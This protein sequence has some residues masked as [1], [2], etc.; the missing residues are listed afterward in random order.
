MKLSLI[1][2]DVAL[3]VEAEQAG[4]DRIMIDL[5]RDGKAERQAGRGLFLSSH[6]IESVAPVKVALVK[7]P[8][9]VRINPLGESSRS[10]IDALVDGGADF[11]MLP[12]FSG[13]AEARVFLG[14]VRRRARVILLVETRSAASQLRALVGEPGVDEVHIGLNDLS[15]S[16]GQDNLFEPIC[17]GI[18]DEMAAVLRAAGMPFG[19]G[20]IG[21]LSRQELPVHPERML[22]EQVRL[23]ASRGWL[24]RTFRGE[25]EQSRARG[26]LAAE[27]LA[28]REAVRKWQA[29]SPGALL[30]NRAAL[31]REAA[32]FVA[33]T[34]PRALRQERPC[35]LHSSASTHRG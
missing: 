28:I 10:E 11:I 18:I 13:L 33:S 31:H 2:D 14:L 22:A 24:G 8:L 9:V 21:R 25:M 15:I 19:L 7:T 27:V 5:E 12:Y 32:D 1:T 23:G 29:A 26:E 16:L 4:I 20:G 34:D 3:A 30:D 17:T 6:R 35:S